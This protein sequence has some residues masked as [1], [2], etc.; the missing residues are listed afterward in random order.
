MSVGRSL[1]RAYCSPRFRKPKKF[2]RAA[3]RPPL[4]LGHGAR[5]EKRRGGREE[6]RKGKKRGTKKN[7]LLG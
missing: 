2:A 7:R 5:E 1:L 4:K 3:T 6:E